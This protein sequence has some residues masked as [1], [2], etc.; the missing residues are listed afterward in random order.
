MKWGLHSIIY[1]P[2]NCLRCPPKF[3]FVCG[4]AAT[5][6]AVTLAQFPFAL[7]WNTRSADILICI[8]TDHVSFWFSSVSLRT[9]VKLFYWCWWPVHV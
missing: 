4:A 5:A 1:R 9:Y 2:S 8:N 7:I 6:Q 3:G